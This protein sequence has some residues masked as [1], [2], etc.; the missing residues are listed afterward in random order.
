MVRY[1]VAAAC[2]L[3]LVSGAALAE[4]MAGSKTVTIQRS[5]DGMGTHKV[6][7]KRHVNPYGRMVT[8]RIVK[9]DG[10]YGSSVARSKT[11]HDPMTGETRTRTTIER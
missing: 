4:D 1:L 7:T 5:A 2:A 11:V 3:S 10:F 6:V 8:K 9:R